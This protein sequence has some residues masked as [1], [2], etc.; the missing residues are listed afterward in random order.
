MTHF[1]EGDKAR[2]FVDRGS[3]FVVRGAVVYCLWFGPPTINERRTTI[4]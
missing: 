2:A 4:N 3:L 1:R